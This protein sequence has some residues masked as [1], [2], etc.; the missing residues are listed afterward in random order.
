MYNT[1]RRLDR[2][3]GKIIYCFRRL[4]AS[5]LGEPNKKTKIKKILC[6]KLWGLGNLVVIY[7]LVL[8]I[9]EKFPDAKLIF[10]TLDLNKGLLENNEAVDMVIYF[11]FPKNVFHIIKQF[12]SVLIALREEKIDLVINFEIFN[13]TSAF[14][15]YLIQA[16]LRIGLYNKY[17]KIFYTHS[18]V[19]DGSKHISE[20]FTALLEPLG[21]ISKYTYSH[22]AG[23]DKDRNKIDYILKQHRIHEFFCIHPGTS[24]NFKGKRYQKNCFAELASRFILEQQVSVFFIGK[25]GENRLAG[26]IIKMLP[27]KCNAFDLTNQLTISELVELLRRSRLFFSNDTGPVHIAASLGINVAVVYGPTSPQNYRPLNANSLIFYNNCPCSPCVGVSYTNK[28]CTHG[29]ECLDFSPTEIHAAISQ[30]FFA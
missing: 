30:K 23:T 10:L 29:F 14:F 2:S 1:F 15:S 17:A 6:I 24:N 13:T 18:V 19:H 16:T 26:E 25:D 21:I 7:P 5:R 27:A 11:N 4:F 8:K 20:K 22:L 9:K 12:Y 28:R 3:F